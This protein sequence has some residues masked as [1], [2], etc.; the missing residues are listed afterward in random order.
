MKIQVWL[1]FRCPFCYIGEKRLKDALEMAGI[2]AEIEMMSFELD[3]RVSEEIKGS[4]AQG[5]AIKY[6]M[7]ILEAEA[8]LKRTEEMAKASGL[9]MKYDTVKDANTFKAHKV[10]QYAKEQGMGNEFTELGMA[11]YFNQG[12]HLGQD[13]T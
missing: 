6:G 8:N 12:K 7:S 3:P 1:D 5:L 2:D 11:G 10:L 9:V 4:V 13:E